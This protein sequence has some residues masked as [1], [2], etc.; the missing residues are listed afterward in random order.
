M[1]VLRKRGFTL[2][3]LLV[4][5]AIIAI[6]I[7]L[8]LPAVQAARE[9]AR[10]STCR[11]NLKQ[12]A[13]ALHNYHENFLTYPPESIW[14]YDGGG[15]RSGGEPRN[16][17]WIALILPQLDERALYE[18]IN[19][20]APILNQTTSTGRKVISEK[21]PQLICPSD[22]GYGEANKWNV[23]WTCYAGA[24]GWSWWGY[25]TQSPAPQHGGIFTLLQA[26]REAQIED[27]QSNVILVG[28][29]SSHSKTGHRYGG[30]GRDRIGNGGVFRSSL[31]ASQV[32][33][34]IATSTRTDG[35]RPYP[36]DLLAPNGDRYTW[37]QM[38]RTPY[39]YKP[40]YVDHYGI[41]SEWPGADSVHEEGAH[42]AMADGRVKFISDS[43]QHTGSS[44]SRL[45]LWHS[46]N[47]K[48]SGPW[49]HRNTTEF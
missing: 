14:T 30:H 39:A 45:N 19:F 32:H 10:R 27:G 22:P 15:G 12:V 29:V 37:W 48:Q 20:S 23:A 33:P 35:Y 42:F 24:E 47:T 28:E 44:D 36:I 26:T 3:E 9:A 7:A 4:V 1:R 16:F 41:N 21:L 40:T 25:G 31:V 2:I 6:L 49:E 8:L 38:W 13:L 11:N 5:I 43:I 34:T 18:Q 17:T 46:I